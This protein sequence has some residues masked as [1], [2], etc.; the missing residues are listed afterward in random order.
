MLGVL[1]IA[2]MVSW[3]IWGL[4]TVALAISVI[5]LAWAHRI[6]SRLEEASDSIENAA[7]DLELL[8]GVLELIESERFSAPK[9]IE[10][11][12]QL[13]HDQIVPHDAIRKLA[14]VVGYLESRRNPA[15]RLLDVLT[16]WSAQCVF[17]AEGWQQE[18]GPMIRGGSRLPGS[19]KHSLRCQAT[20]MNMWAMYFP[21]L[22]STGRYSMARVLHIRYCLSARQYKTT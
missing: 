16:F 17:V 11:Q 19:S 20:R 4:G 7:Q 22:S 1:W 10:I 12:S 14:R 2:G 5:N 6:H 8:A 3:G 21:S 18:F 15:M 9:L 13:K